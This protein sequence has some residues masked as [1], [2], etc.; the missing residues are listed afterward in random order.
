DVVVKQIPTQPVLSVRTIIEDF[1]VGMMIY[2]QIMKALPQKT[3]YGLF[4]VLWH[5]GGF[6]ERDSDVEIC[7]MVDAQSHLP[8]PLTDDLQ[9]RFRE[10]PAVQTMA[11]FVIKGSLENMHVGYSA[12]GTWAE[13][14]H[15]RFLDAPREVLLNF[16]QLPDGSDG[17]IEIQ[18]P[19]EPV[20]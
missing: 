7:R 10:L 5:T 1:S 14:N 20:R 18:F 15:Y 4:I 16:P 2:G 6:F 17:I 12:I 11:T 13:V 19:V 8:V 3:G 9:L